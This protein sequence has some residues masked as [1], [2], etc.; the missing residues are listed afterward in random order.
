MAEGNGRSAFTEAN[1]GNEEMDLV[2]GTLFQIR[3][4]IDYD[5]EDDDEDELY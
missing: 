5:Y 4:Q 3:F 2:T 1:E